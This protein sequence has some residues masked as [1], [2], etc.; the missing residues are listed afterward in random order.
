M[1]VH[2]CRVK[3]WAPL[4]AFVLLVLLGTEVRA[5]ERVENFRLTDHQGRSHELYH[6]EDSSAVVLFSFAPDCEVARATATGLQE[7]VAGMAESAPAVLGVNAVAEDNREAVAEAMGE[8]PLSILMDPA[9]RIAHALGFQHTGEVLLIN[10]KENWRVLYRGGLDPEALKGF[11]T[12]QSLAATTTPAQGRAISY[13]DYSQVS[14]ARD[15]VPILESKC[16]SCHREGGLGPFAMSDYKK[17]MGWGEMIRETVR[18]KRMPPWHADPGVGAFKHSRALTPEQE[19]KLLAWI[20]A[21]AP[22]G[23]EEDTLPEAVAKS[24]PV[25][26]QLGEPDH[27]IRLPEVQELPAAGI[28]NYRYIPVAANIDEDKWVRAIEV[29][30]TNPAVVHHALI[31]INYPREYRHMQPRPHKGLRG[32]FASYLP[33][34]QILPLPDDAGVFLPKGSVL[35]F[36]MHYNPT[37]KPETDQTEMGLYFHDTVPARAVRIEA[38]HYNDFIIPPNAKDHPSRCRYE[39]KQDAEILGLSP[40]MHFRGSRFAF[41]VKHPDDSE[42]PLLNV[43]FYEFDWQPMYFLE[44]PLKVSKGARMIC[45]GAFDNS[46]FNKKNPNPDQFVPFGEQ[47]FQEMFIGYVQFATQRNPDDYVPQELTPEQRIGVGVPITPENIVGMKFRIVEEL[48]VEFMP[49]GKVN[50]LQGDPFGTYEFT[51][52][53]KIQTKS[54]FGPIELYVVGDELYYDGEPTRRVG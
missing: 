45:E 20:E 39:F 34:A 38:G 41:T 7:L 1:F 48:R 6:L 43:P 47:S 52:A 12:G 17:V 27:L 18:T 36:Q 30:A 53:G 24:A 29:R 11:L 33:G 15:I 22:Q 3:L 35:T 50:T 40:H 23:E 32:Y 2:Q 8:T 25:K 9:Q 10:P 51:D 42:Q 5:A 14:Y 44:E 21:G 31:F 54:L 16:L 37:G 4:T 46:R 13:A 26:W 49:D 19:A 28:V